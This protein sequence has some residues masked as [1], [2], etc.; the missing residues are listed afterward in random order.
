MHN[1]RKLFLWKLIHDLLPIKIKLNS[2]FLIFSITCPLCDLDTEPIDHLFIRFPLITQL[3]C[4]SKWNFSTAP[5]TNSSLKSWS[6]LILDS[7]SGL[8]PNNF[9]RAE[10]IVYMVV[11]FDSIWKSMNHIIHGDSIPPIHISAKWI[12]NSALTH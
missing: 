2:L 3:W 12:S 11:L 9:D 6:I 10:F 1:R 8:V 5:F 7:K 4:I